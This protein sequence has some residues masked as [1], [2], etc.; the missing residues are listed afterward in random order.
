[1]FKRHKIRRKNRLFFNNMN[2]DDP[3]DEGGGGIDWREPI[4]DEGLR[5]ACVGL[6]LIVSYYD[7]ENHLRTKT[8]VQIENRSRCSGVRW[9]GATGERQQ[10]MIPSLLR[11]KSVCTIENVV[12]DG[13]N[14]FADLMRNYDTE[15]LDRKENRIIHGRRSMKM[16]AALV[17]FSEPHGVSINWYFANAYLREWKTLPVAHGSA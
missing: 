8:H 16:Y 1:M 3:S 7:A 4:L 11:R 15:R 9:A 13:L 6:D 17:T 5:M 2:D 10:L 12:F 14:T